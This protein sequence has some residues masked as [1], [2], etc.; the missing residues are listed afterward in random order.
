MEIPTGLRFFFQVVSCGVV[1]GLGLV[2]DGLIAQQVVP[3]DALNSTNDEVLLGWD[4]S[5]L[6]YRSIPRTSD[7]EKAGAW[8]LSQGQEY[9]ALPKKGWASFTDGK[10]MNL[11]AWSAADWPGIGEVQHVAIDADRGVLV[12]SA[13][14]PAGDFDLFMAQRSGSEWTSPLPL[15]G[16]NT[17]ADEVF[18]N[19]DSGALLFA[20]NGHPGLGGFDI[21][22]SERR[23]HYADCT[24][25]QKGVNTAGDELA[26]VSDGSPA[27][28]GYYVSAVRMGGQGVD[29]YWVGTFTEDNARAKKELAVEVVYRRVPVERALFEIHDRSGVLLMSDATD[30]QGRLVL[31]AVELDAALEVKV[32]MESGRSIPDGAVCHVYELCGPAD[33][34]ETHWPGWRR[35]RSYRIEGGAAFVFD[36]LPLDALERWPRPSAQDAALWRGDFPSCKVNFATAEFTLSKTVEMQILQ[37]LEGLNWSVNGGYFEVRGFTDSQGEVVRNQ[38]LSEQR[39]EETA[40]VLVRLGVKSSRIKWSGHGVAYEGTTEADQRRVEVRW[41]EAIE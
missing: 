16:L 35:V 3:L 21:Y 27:S 31:G 23:S 17:T 25:L 18:P 39:A 5:S 2:G 30:G 1:L 24:P 6:F 29:L 15:T 26:A 37:W 10:P 8:F 22:R 13:L 9:M 38:V 11:R 28:Q 20:S 41:V 34:G 19:F 40:R 4:G 14:Q 7:T 32:S 12:M 33:C 36:L